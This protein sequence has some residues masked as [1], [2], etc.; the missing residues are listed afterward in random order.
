VYDWLC[1]VLK[2]LVNNA[3][4]SIP[5]DVL[6]L[7]LEHVDKASLA[8]IC[9]VNKIC[10]S[11]SQDVLYRDMQF[12]GYS[13][14]IQVYQLLAQSTHLAQ[15]VRSFELRR[16]NYEEGREEDLRKCFRN[17]IHLRS[18]RLDV[19]LSILDGCT[20]KL[21]SFANGFCY[22]GSLN[23]FLNTQPS[24]TDITLGTCMDTYELRACLPNLTR[25]TSRFSWLPQIIPNRPVNEVIS[26]GYTHF[27]GSID[28]GFFALSTSPIQKLTM[29]QSY[30]HPR[31][32]RQLAS[33]FPSLTYLN[34]TANSKYTF[35]HIVKESSFFKFIYILMGLL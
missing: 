23:R 32:G 20:F 19:D 4:P 3:M 10:C 9:R 29:D 7:I 34:I 1:L 31:P 18:L 22:S 33:I 35:A 30:L 16:F 27:G 25:V 11:C 28:F 2:L 15:R 13:E 17:M 12:Y 24:L 8:K 14:D 5:V 21:V 6:R 26:L